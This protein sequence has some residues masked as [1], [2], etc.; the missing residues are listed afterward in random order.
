MDNNHR[1]IPSSEFLP[2]HGILLSVAKNI[3]REFESAYFKN[4][5][6]QSRWFGLVLLLL[7]SPLCLA[8]EIEDNAG[9]IPMKVE[10]ATHD[11]NT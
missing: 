7:T 2:G 11:G 10:V 5:G 4:S 1:L 9:S 8:Q 3:K 6:S